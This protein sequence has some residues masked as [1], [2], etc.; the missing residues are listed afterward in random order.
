MDVASGARLGRV[1]DLAGQRMLINRLVG[2]NHKYAF[3]ARSLFGTT[4]GCVAKLRGGK[5]YVSGLFTHPFNP[6]CGANGI[7][8]NV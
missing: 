3:L 7:V 8:W 4:S 5:R 2:V 6:D 1:N